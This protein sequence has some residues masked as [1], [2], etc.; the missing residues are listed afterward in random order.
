MR[1]ILASASPRRR[2]LLKQI[3]LSFEVI[4]SPANEETALPM[5]WERARELAR[6]KAGAVF[7]SLPGDGDVL[8]IGADTLVAV[9][10]RILGKP[11]GEESA[12]EM[13]ELLSGRTHQVYT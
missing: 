7:G 1:I 3:G 12:V 13:L 10:G 4:V 2:E 9:E 11:V 8:V 5:V 6:R